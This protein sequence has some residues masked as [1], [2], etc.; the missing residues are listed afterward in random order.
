MPS[1]IL[2]QNASL[3]YIEMTRAYLLSRGGVIIQIPRSSDDHH[4]IFFFLLGHCFIS[5]TW[6]VVGT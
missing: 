6:H 5:S 2:F 4:G 3:V 1:F